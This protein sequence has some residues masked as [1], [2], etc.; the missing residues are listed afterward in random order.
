MLIVEIKKKQ[1]RFSS[2]V[3]YFS[4]DNKVLLLKRKKYDAIDYA[5]KWGLV[6]GKSEE[7]E[8]PK[9]AAIR[10]TNEESGLKVLPEDLIMI[11][12]IK[13]PQGYP[14][15]VFACKKFQ[16]TVNAQNVVEEHDDYRW[17]SIDKVN[18]YDT[19]E[20]TMPLIKKAISM[21]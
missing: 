7:G 5:G 12:T 16:G 17:V 4:D 9:E 10:E 13:S 21:V 2:I 19:P 14:V 20:N 11:A 15:H 8:T 3:F 18:K 1:K 6:G